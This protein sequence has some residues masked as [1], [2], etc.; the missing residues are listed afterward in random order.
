MHPVLIRLGPLT[1]HSYGVFVALAFL[2][3][4]WWATREAKRRGLNTD[5]LPGLAFRIVL[6]AVL[7]ARLLYVLIDLPYFL[8]RPTEIVAFWNGGLVF[9]GGLTFA[10]V[11]G[12]MKLRR[13]PHRLAW[14][15]ALAPAV[16]LGQGIGRLGCFLAGCCY[17]AKTHVPWTVIFSDPNG[18]A[19][20]GT[21]VHPAQ[22]YQ[23]AAGFLTFFA[24][25]WFSRRNPTPGRTAGLYLV[26]FGAFR[27]FV[28]FFR[29]DWRG[30][31]GFASVTQV[32]TGIFL[33]LGLHLLTRNNRSYANA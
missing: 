33:L 30:D 22:L 25:I 19:P 14:C 10:A 31:F 4:I 2:A 1:L 32:V 9:S 3:A 23:S 8:Q 16:A 7:G 26:L 12:F 17:G 15:D 29:A 5:I 27:I 6:G 18:L 24:L 21:P 28:E 11:L 20:I 13:E